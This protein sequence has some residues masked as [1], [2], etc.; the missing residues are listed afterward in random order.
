MGA[1]Q[2]NEDQDKGNFRLTCNSTSKKRT[3]FSGYVGEGR[4]CPGLLWKYL[5][6]GTLHHTNKRKSMDKDMVQI[7]LNQAQKEFLRAR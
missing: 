7:Q 2:E 3:V 6:F 4:C 1:V 5:L